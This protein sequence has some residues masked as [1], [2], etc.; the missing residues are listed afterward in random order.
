MSI[1]LSNRLLGQTL[2][3]FAGAAL[4]FTGISLT[5]SKVVEVTPA[6]AQISETLLPATEN[7]SAT[8]VFTGDIMLNRR[9]EMM[10]RSNGNYKFPFLKIADDLKKADVLFGNL[11]GPISDKGQK[12]GSIY[13]FRAE[14]EAIEGLTYAGFDVLSLANNHAFD[15]GKEALEDTFLRL[16]KAE[17]DYVGAG[18]NGTEAFSPLIK[19]VNGL[20]IGFLA[21]TNLGPKTWRAGSGT[22]IAWVNEKSFEDL[23]NNIS[24]ARTKVDILI[25]S[26]HAGEEYIADPSQFQVDFSHAAIDAGADIVIGHHPHITQKEEEYNGGYIFYSLG[27]F[28]FDQSFSEKTMQGE[29]VKV[30]VEDGKI[31]EVSPVSI[32]LN[33]SF[34]PEIIDNSK[35]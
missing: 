13:S 34:Q 24:L 30:V 35:I 33:D 12:V 19:E 14:P 20:K 26:L 17:I 31:K 22:G 29:M 2:I 28:V 3:I 32:K 10:M 23:K 1:K 18:L 16:K 21:Y 4:L 7:K 27:N 9:V 6:K 8:L 5:K 15:Y 11:E 25:V